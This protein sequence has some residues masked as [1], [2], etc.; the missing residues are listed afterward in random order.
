MILDCWAHA[1]Q[2]LGI[3]TEL[4]AALKL[5]QSLSAENLPADG[6]YSLTPD[7]YYMVVQRTLSPARNRLEFHRQFIDIHLPLSQEEKIGVF[8]VARLP[9]NVPFSPETDAGLYSAPAEYTVAVPPGY[10]CIC[11]PQDAH[12]PCIGS[13]AQSIRKIIFK[14]RS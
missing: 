14:I 9:E 4:D 11:F 7:S 1:G 12:E 2:Y 3:S 10:F 6:H 13:E 8:P 5:I